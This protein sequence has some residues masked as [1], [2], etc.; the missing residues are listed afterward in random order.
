[1]FS[2]S[3]NNEALG[4]WHTLELW[5]RLKKLSLQQCVI[6][7]SFTLDDNL[8]QGALDYFLPLSAEN[9][10]VAYWPRPPRSR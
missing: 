3:N 2:S 5:E 9:T 4:R 1:M 10:H 7:P 6:S 8:V